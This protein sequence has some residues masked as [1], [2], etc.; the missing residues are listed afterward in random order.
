MY[1]DAVNIGVIDLAYHHGDARTAL[2]GAAGEWLEE[3][4]AVSLSLRGVADRAG[5][6]RQAPYNHFAD[7]EAML[8]ALVANGFGRLASD[9]REASAG[10]NGAAA[11]AAAGEAY[12]AFAQG[13]PA[14]FRLMFARELVDIAKFADAAA[15][16]ADAF[17]VLSGIV[18][19]L[20]PAG[21]EEDVGLAA[22]CIVH[23]YATLC[24]EV[25]IEPPERRTER[26]RQFTRMIVTSGVVAADGGSTNTKEMS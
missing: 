22:W 4:G 6:S 23:G 10:K 2:I 25:G 11:L 1:V 9:L 26:A 12:I 7:K 8:A 16:S 20:S 17:S 21:Q 18:V 24:N 14:L 19:A 3:V 15:A 13:R 5:L